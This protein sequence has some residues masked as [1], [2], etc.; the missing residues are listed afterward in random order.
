MITRDFTFASNEDWRAAAVLADAGD[1][2]GATVLMQVKP[3]AGHP[4]AWLDL[5]SVAGLTVD[6]GTKTVSW[7]VA[8]A[9]IAGIPP[10]VYAYD[11]VVQ[12]AGGA[13]LR[14]ATGTVTI[15]IGVTDVPRAAGTH[16]LE[17]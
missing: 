13:T 7:I 6:V 8:Q 3:C 9:D 1:L 17:V 15:D 16:V 2:A 10:G 11:I 4:D 5:S 12:Y 14:E